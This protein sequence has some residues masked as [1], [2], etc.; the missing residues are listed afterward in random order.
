[1]IRIVPG[2]TGHDVWLV[3]DR[4]EGKWLGQPFD[5]CEWCNESDRIAIERAKHRLLFPEW[6]EWG[7][8]YDQLSELDRVVWERNRGFSANYQD[9]WLDQLDRANQLGEITD[10]ELANSVDRFVRWLNRIEN[11]RNAN[12]SSLVFEES[13]LD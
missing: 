1:M 11:T 6:L 5:E 7:E 9:K 3:C 4:C 2:A 12:K 8:R 13:P 10:H